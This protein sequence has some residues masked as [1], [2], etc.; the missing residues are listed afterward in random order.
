VDP[1]AG[2]RRHLATIG[3]TLGLNREFVV[4]VARRG[5]DAVIDRTEMV[6]ETG[7]HGRMLAM[8]QQLGMARQDAAEKGQQLPP[9]AIEQVC[10]M[11]CRRYQVP[12][13]IGIKLLAAVDDTFR[14]TVK[15]IAHEATKKELYPDG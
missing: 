5:Q 6:D 9:G 7:A 1:E 10:T 4:D 11:L 3:D 13:E 15:K 2:N 8:V 12:E 14:R